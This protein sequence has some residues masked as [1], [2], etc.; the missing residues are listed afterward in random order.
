MRTNKLLFALIGITWDH[1]TVAKGSIAFKHHCR[2]TGAVVHR[3]ELYSRLNRERQRED[4]NNGSCRS[5]S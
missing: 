3:L 4:A 5:L 2:V 1:H